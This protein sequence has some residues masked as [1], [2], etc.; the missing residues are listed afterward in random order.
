MEMINSEKLIREIEKHNVLYDRSVK[1]YYN[2]NVKHLVWNKVCAVVYPIWNQL[3]DLEKCNY[4]EY[5]F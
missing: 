5:A 2:K 3:N 4:C 1:D